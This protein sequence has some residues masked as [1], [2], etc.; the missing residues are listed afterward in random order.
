MLV[1][2]FPVK[3]GG[4]LAPAVQLDVGIAVAEEEV[5]QAFRVLFRGKTLAFCHKEVGPV[6]GGLLLSMVEAGEELL[7]PPDGE[8]IV[9]KEGDELIRNHAREEGVSFQQCI[10]LAVRPYVIQ[11]T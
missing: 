5:R 6:E 10:W 8:Q 1:D 7:N 4:D 3:G 9:D 2:E 11:P